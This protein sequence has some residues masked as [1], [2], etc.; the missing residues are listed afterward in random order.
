MQSRSAVPATG[1]LHCHSLLPLHHDALFYVQSGHDS[2]CSG[3]S[4][5]NACCDAKY[6]SCQNRRIA[7]QNPIAHHSCTRS[8][9]WRHCQGRPL[10][11]GTA[12]GTAPRA[13]LLM[14]RH[15]PTHGAAALERQSWLLL[16]LPL[17]CQ[18]AAAQGHTAACAAVAGAVLR[19]R[20]LQMSARSGIVI[21]ATAAGPIVTLRRV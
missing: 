1:R 20:T 9:S 12:A 18:R 15:L 7:D 4:G 2:I 8:P 19:R 3:P 13:C 11:G 5:N 6:A 16:P 21:S 10:K 17:A 14:S